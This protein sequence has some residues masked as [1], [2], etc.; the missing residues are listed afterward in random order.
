[1]TTPSPKPSVIEKIE[2]ARRKEYARLHIAF[3]YHKK[4]EY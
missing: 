1:M 2:A 3:A 4:A